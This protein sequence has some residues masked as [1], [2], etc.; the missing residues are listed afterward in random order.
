M[1]PESACDLDGLRRFLRQAGMQGLINPAAARSRLNAVDQ[2]AAGLT[3]DERRDLRQV[4]VDALVARFHKLEGESIRPEALDIYAQRLRMALT[5]FLTWLEQPDGFVS[6]GQERARATPRRAQEP[7]KADPTQ[8]AAERIVLQATEN[9]TSI[10]PVPIR[11][12]VTVYV[13]NLPINLSP[14]EADRIAR[15][16]QAFART[17]SDEPSS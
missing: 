7:G 6:V 1:G 17:D 8:D 14:E 4:D 9:P 12:D 5:D 2:L 13:A 16:I 15:I 10:V 11:D 3:A